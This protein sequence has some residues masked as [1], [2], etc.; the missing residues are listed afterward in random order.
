[1][2]GGERD[3]TAVLLERIMTTTGELERSVEVITKVQDG[4]IH[5]VTAM[6]FRMRRVMRW[7]IAGLVLDLALTGGGALLY[8]RVVHNADRISATQERQ[9]GTQPGLCALYDL[10]LD[11][12]NHESPSYRA[13]PAAYE[14]SFRQLEASATV[15]GCEHTTKG[16][17]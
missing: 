6:A 9:A 15:A 1:M 17:N 3:E 2:D 4:Q 13:D 16:R 5:D 10:F 14:A 8:R 11:S 12:Y 7:V